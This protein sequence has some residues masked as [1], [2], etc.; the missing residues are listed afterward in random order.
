[1]WRRMDADAPT[2]AEKQHLPSESWPPRA[3]KTKFFL[4]GAQE[5]HGLRKEDCNLANSVS[6]QI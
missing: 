5:K 2:G 6:Q 3:G 4:V 1:M